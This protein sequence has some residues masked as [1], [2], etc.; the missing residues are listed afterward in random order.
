M[1][2]KNRDYED[3]IDLSEIFT[4]LWNRKFVIILITTIFA[5]VSVYYSL[6]LP[7]IYSSSTVLAPTTQ[8][9][10]LDSKLSG[11]RSLAGIAGINI[12]KGQLTQ[13]EESVERMISY[14]F[15]VSEFLPYVNLEDLMA[16]EKWIPETN[17]IIYNEEEFDN[18]NSEWIRKASFPSESLPS[19]QEAYREYQGLID[20]DVSEKNSLVTLTVEHHSPYIAKE[21]VALIVKNINNHMRELDKIEAEN[22]IIFLQDASKDN[23]I[24]EIQAVISELLRTQIQTLMLVEAN[25]NYV[26][27]TISSPLVPEKKSKPARAILCIFGTIIG[28]IFSILIVLASAFINNKRL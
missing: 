12:P 9:D 16:V 5:I 20:L 7:N 22:S 8:D 25:I 19:K 18:K 2:N 13:S 6:S 21:W 4:T 27:K 1:E 11:Y 3:D 28:F 24:F 23:N 17:Q 26:F 14:D 10:S 15:F